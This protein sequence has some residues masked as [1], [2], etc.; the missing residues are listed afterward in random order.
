MDWIKF[1]KAKSLKEVVN[2]VSKNV[3]F[4]E[5]Y[6]AIKLGLYDV[7]NE[8]KWGWELGYWYKCGNTDY[9]KE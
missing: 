2:R 1:E 9:V 4:A 8:K 5:N 6:S 3:Y 7:K